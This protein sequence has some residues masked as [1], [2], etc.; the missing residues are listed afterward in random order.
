MD[1]NTDS[2]IVRLIALSIVGGVAK[3]LF[4]KPSVINRTVVQ[5]LAET[6]QEA[7]KRGTSS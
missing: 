2:P 4:G 5:N 3:S 7:V 6:A 1:R